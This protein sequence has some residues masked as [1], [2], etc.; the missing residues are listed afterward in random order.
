MK[1]LPGESR[2]TPQVHPGGV[3]Q[4]KLSSHGGGVTSAWR[5]L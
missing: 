2:S 5:G 4:C 1:P 3:W